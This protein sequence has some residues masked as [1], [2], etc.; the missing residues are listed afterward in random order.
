M[1]LSATPRSFNLSMQFGFNMQ[2]ELLNYIE[3]NSITA[4]QAVESVVNLTAL[5]SNQAVSLATLFPG[6]TSIV[7]FGFK[8]ISNPGVVVSWG[9]ASGG[10]RITGRANS[11][12]LVACNGTIPTLYFDNASAS[13]CNL[14]IFA[15]GS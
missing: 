13:I 12:I 7:A 10:A 5:T 11:A 14:L 9:L 1:V 3:S 15:V 6:L 8:D 4:A 2:N